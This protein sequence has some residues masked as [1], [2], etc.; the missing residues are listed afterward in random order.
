MCGIACFIGDG[1]IMD[2]FLALKKLEYRGYDSAG[3][4]YICRSEL[5]THKVA[6]YVDNLEEFASRTTS[7]VAIG[8]TR[9]ATHGAP[10]SQNAHPHLSFDGSLAVVHNGIIENYAA[11]KAQLEAEGIG[12]KSQTD[13]EVLC[14]LVASLEGP[15]VERLAR[16]LEMVE[17]SFA[18]CFLEKSGKVF[19]V[20][21]GC[22]LY[23][24][25]GEG[26]FMLASDLSCFVGKASEF[27]ALEDADILEVSEGGFYLYNKGRQ[28]TPSFAPLAA[29]E[30]DI[31]LDG[32]DYFM[33]KEICAIPKI[34]ARF[35]EVYQTPSSYFCAKEIF[36]GAEQVF[37]VGCGTAYHACLFGA[38]MM[39]EKVGLVARPFIASELKTQVVSTRGAVA[40]LVSQS[41]ETA[42]TIGAM[43]MLK[44]RGVKC[45]AV[46]NA[47][48]STLALESDLVIPILAG[49]EVA[50]ASTKAYVGQLL[51]LLGLVA[52]LAKKP[53]AGMEQLEK[54]CQEAINVESGVINLIKGARRVFFIGRGVDSITSLEAALKLKEIT[55]ISAEGYAAGELKHGTIALIEKGTPVVVIITDERLKDKTLSNLKEVRARGA[56]VVLVSQ[57]DGLEDQGD[58]LIK[59]P[60]LASPELY[61]V[62]AVIPMQVLA[63]K[64]C[65]AK[66]F[67]PDKP[68]NLAKSVT[69]E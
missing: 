27:Y 20:R 3:M 15:M 17:G 62:V 23:F 16:V 51:A 36:A 34:A 43:R 26:G 67:D 25:K 30:E 37:F 33:N 48:H 52:S 18:C 68:R 5:C 22:P 64:V 69:V 29:T 2:C 61:S 44:E 60:K 47:A 46:T 8:H 38:R 49:K 63:Y 40:V 50:V 6:G 53:V 14:S 65:L 7:R 12:F 41:G 32:Y 55:Y 57:L 13:T 10:T 58:F 54:A 1:A 35:A 21:R 42:D 59:L 19:A 4:A 45:V 39:E 24:A 56:K 28:K 31:S 66:G 11:I 9:W